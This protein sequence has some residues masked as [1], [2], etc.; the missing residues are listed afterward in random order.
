VT[1][2]PIIAVL[3]RE[4]TKMFRQRSRLVAAM[5]RPLI[6]LF[7]IGAGFEAIL[8]RAGQAGYQSFLVPGVVGMN[9]LFAAMLSAVTM[10][11]DKESGVMRM[12]IIGPFARGWIVIAKMIAATVTSIVQT[13]VLLLILAVLSFVG[14]LQHVDWSAI[15]WPLL[16]LGILLTSLAC[17]GIGMLVASWITSLDNFAVVMNFVTF[18]VF[19]LSGALYPIRQ[20]PHALRIVAYLNPYTYGVDLLKHATLIN[21]PANLRADLFVALDIT[22]LVGFTAAAT[23]IACYRFSREEAYAPLFPTPARK[24]G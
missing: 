4:L 7:V 8:A 1:L 17:A 13:S 12:L 19:F 18:P 5:I 21:P 2:R 6:W 11:Y 16:A 23:A 14:A 10:V 20:L 15:D 3:D 22:V 9:M 24:I